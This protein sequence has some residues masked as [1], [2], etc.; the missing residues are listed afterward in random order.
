MPYFIGI[1][2]STT[3]TKALL[4]D[5]QGNVVG[6]AAAEYGFETPQ[7]L[8][9][10]QDPQLW[11]VGAVESIRDVLAES[12]IDPAE[13]AGLGLT[14]QMHGLVLLDDDG[15]VLRP[16]ILWNDQRTAAQ[17]D[18]IRERV[19]LQRLI[20]ITGNEALTGFTAPKI[21][22]VAENEPDIY[23]KVK[24]ILLPKDYLRYKL[25]GV[26]ATDK[27]GAGGTL[28]IDLENRD[29]SMEILEKAGDRS[30]LDAADPRRDRRSRER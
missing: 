14:G 12:G 30:S 19:G 9:S 3:A 28:L 15:N 1:D 27:A 22:W 8:W 21:L 2:S 13:V 25:T 20:D 5:E 11:W 17:C 7:P 18:T 24:H 16:S 10:E 23:A 6:V 26:M 4:M 29:W